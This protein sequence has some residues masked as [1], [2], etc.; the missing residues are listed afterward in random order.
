MKKFLLAMALGLAGLIPTAG[1]LHADNF[2]WYFYGRERLPQYILNEDLSSI[3]ISVRPSVTPDPPL[4]ADFPSV[5]NPLIIIIVWPDD[6]QEVIHVTS[7][8]LNG[9][10]WI[11]IPKR[12]YRE[13]QIYLEGHYQLIFTNIP[14]GF[15]FPDIMSIVRLYN[16]TLETGSKKE[17]QRWLTNPSFWSSYYSEPESRQFIFWLDRADRG[18][19]G[20]GFYSDGTVI[21]PGD[22]PETDE[23]P[24]P[25]SP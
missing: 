18:A 16:G 23:P 17:I 3:Y 24:T 13:Q 11:Y 10:N 14:S 7:L 9:P 12:E 6:H 25:P 21:P 20:P 8:N 4:T 1:T 19:K 5:E 2:P 15:S 22:Y